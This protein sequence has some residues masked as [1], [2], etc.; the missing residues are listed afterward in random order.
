M[1]DF[2]LLSGR[3]SLPLAKKI[4]NILKKEIDYPITIFSDGEVRVR[5]SPNLRSRHVFIIQSTSSPVNDHL[6]ELILMIDAAKR[7]S[8]KAITA[9]IPYFG[10]SRQDRKEMPRVPISSSTVAG[11]IQHV[12]AG[13]IVTVDIHSE[14]QQGFVQIPWDN[15][16]A[17]YSLVPAIRS[18]KLSSLIIASPDKGGMTRATGYAK[19]LKA[20]GIALV[21]KER[22]ITLNNKS[23]T[24][25]MIGDVKGKDVLIV[26]DMIDTA[27]TIVHAANYLKKQGARRV[28]ASCAHGLFSGPALERINS[29]A[30]DEVI[31]TDTINLKDEVLKNKK[32]KVASV[33]PLIA[34]AI[35]RINTGA[36]L[37]K[38]LFL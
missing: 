21:Y 31:A 19:L 24:L 25:G 1:D 20:K 33:A 32:I 16:Y 22:D 12:G 4:A 9:I 35:R 28:L 15:L 2:V 14:Q 10:Y 30:I 27:G 37:T 29:S 11:I 13:R 8:A 36:S 3:A 6:M 17:S 26:D 38:E 7:A 5:V 18:K 23:E 34:K